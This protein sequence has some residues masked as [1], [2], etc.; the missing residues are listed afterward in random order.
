[1]TIEIGENLCELL[2]VWGIF[3]WLSLIGAG[4]CWVVTRD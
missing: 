3:G 4:V 2:Q 1:M